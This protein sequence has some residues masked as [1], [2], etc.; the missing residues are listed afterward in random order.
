LNADFCDASMCVDQPVA[1]L[2]VL[3]PRR[4]QTPP[5]AAQ[6]PLGRGVISIVA[7][8]WDAFDHHPGHLGRRD[9]P[10][11]LRLLAD[12]VSHIE[13]SRQVSIRSGHAVSAAHEPSST[14]PPRQPCQA[15][16]A[17]IDSWS[18]HDPGATRKT[19]A[20]EWVPASTCSIGGRSHTPP[21]CRLVRVPA[22]G[23]RTSGRRRPAHPA[24]TR[25]NARHRG[26]HRETP[27]LSYRPGRS[28]AWIK[29]ALRNRIEVVGGWTPGKGNRTNQ[30]GALLLGQ[31]T[32]PPAGGGQREIEFVGAVGTGWTIAI[33]R[34]L[35][36]Q[37]TEFG[38]GARV[39]GS[40]VGAPSTLTEPT[41]A[42]LDAVVRQLEALG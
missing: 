2:D 28:P 32:P 35:L 41:S 39:I 18:A 10:R 20:T 3:G 21:P 22:A 27:R 14:R 42:P 12:H 4:H 29:H 19:H 34:Q 37:L 13:L 9:V 11:R 17:S 25:P 24:R 38:R 33:A 5:R 8:A 1:D 15:S 16:P 30:L 7:P 40:V 6:H 26:C 36:Q 23:A 31:P